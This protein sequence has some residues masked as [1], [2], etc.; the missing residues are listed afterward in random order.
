[1]EP[2]TVKQLDRMAPV[3]L[4]LAAKHGLSH[5]R[6]AGAGR[7][8]ADLDEDRTYFDVAHFE[9]EAEA[10]LRAS[11]HVVASGAPSAANLAGRE[12]TVTTAA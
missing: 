5:L 11:V 3:L 6:H 12:L 2:A 7:V 8:V 10:V 4:A 1:M 9:L